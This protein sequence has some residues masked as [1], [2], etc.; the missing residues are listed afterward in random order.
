LCFQ[1]IRVAVAGY[2]LSSALLLF[3]NKYAMFYVPNPTVISMVQVA[4]VCLVVGIVQLFNIEKVDRLEEHKIKPYLLYIF[5]FF[6]AMYTNMKALAATSVETVIVFRAVTPLVVCFLEYIYLD[7]NL[8]SVKSFIFLFLVCGG[9]LMYAFYEGDMNIEGEAA[10]YWVFGY[11]VF[12]SLEITYGK[13]LTSTVRMESVW[14]AVYYCNILSLLPF[15]AF[16]SYE[17][18]LVWQAQILLKQQSRGVGLLLVSCLLAVGIR[19]FS[20]I[21]TCLTV[22]NF[23]FC[24]LS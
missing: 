16:A 22:L 6:C 5:L 19:Y 14:G 17:G 9:S 12:S 1:Q 13:H 20:L 11:L 4:F 21:I 15:I 23:V 18:E 2:A 3:V 8:P 24:I 7:R 10:H